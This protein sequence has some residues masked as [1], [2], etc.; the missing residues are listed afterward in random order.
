[1]DSLDLGRVDSLDLGRETL[2]SLDFGRLESRDGGLPLDCGLDDLP[3]PPREPGLEEEADL[4]V[5]LEPVLELGLEPV[6][7][8]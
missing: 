2:E 7:L 3:P 5:G 8:L 1:M 6:R 4:E